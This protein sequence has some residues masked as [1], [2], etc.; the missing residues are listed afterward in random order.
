MLGSD[1]AVD[2]DSTGHPHV[3]PATE[4]GVSLVLARSAVERW[5]V[6]IEGTAEWTPADAPADVTLSTAGLTAI[7]HLDAPDLVAT[8]QAGVRWSSLRAALAEHGT[9][10]AVDPPGD[11]RTVGSVTAT[12]T[13]GPLRAGFGGV[14]D[15]VLG[16]TLV[17]GDGRVIRPGGRVVKNVAGFDL[18]KLAAGGFGAFGVITSVTLRLRAVPRADVTLVT[19]GARDELLAGAWSLLVGG[20]TPA[21]MELM[22]PAAAGE[23]AWLLAVRIVGA[24][25]ALHAER[26]AVNR[27][28]GLPLAELPA[29]AARRLWQAVSI[30][31]TSGVATLRLGAL[32]SALDDALD[33][34]T[35]HLSEEW[36]AVTVS[37]GV[38]RWSGDAAPDRLRQLRHAAAQQEM[39][40][41][42]ERA[43]WHI[44]GEI[45]VFG[46][47]REG[48]GR[49]VGSLQRQFD[50]AGILVSGIGASE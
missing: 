12:G 47:Y 28:A 36:L 29:Q 7:T 17:T 3:A 33:L 11:D 34:V 31:A 10:V 16:L 30:G 9:W 45:G 37:A 18:T 13:A 14:R 42:L 15:H 20:L 22:S 50:P 6:R 48:V 43:P 49:L 2:T 27:T 44:R 41:T 24:P 40:M 38:V 25:A 32:P 21:A 8:A 35:H 23:R 19:Q 26:D 39:P 1:A 46:A 5:T 4:E